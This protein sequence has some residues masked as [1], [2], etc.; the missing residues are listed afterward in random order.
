MSEETISLVDFIKKLDL[1]TEDE[2][3]A[4]WAVLANR[5]VWMDG[6]YVETGSFRWNGGE[7]AKV[8]GGT[9]LDYYCGSGSHEAQKR[10]AELFMDYLVTTDDIENQIRPM[11]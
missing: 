11:T 3:N 6:I 2:G 1:K 9:Y 8:L 4:L 5:D 7:I 10:V